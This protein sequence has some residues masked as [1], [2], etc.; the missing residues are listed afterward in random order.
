MAL[1]FLE[2]QCTCTMLGTDF[3]QSSLRQIRD[4]SKTTSASESLV[5]VFSIF[6]SIVGSTAC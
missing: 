2:T 6:A 3:I 4:R 5:N 1:V